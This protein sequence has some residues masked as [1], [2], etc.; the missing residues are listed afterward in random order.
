MRQ[1]MLPLIEDMQRPVAR[2][3]SFHGYNALLDTG[4]VFPIW[5]EDE[6]ILVDLGGELVKEHIEF[7]GFGGR[8]IGKLFRLPQI[9]VGELIYPN[10]HIIAYKMNMPCYFIM[11]AT[12]FQHLIYEIDD[13]NHTLNITIPDKEHNVRNL[14]IKDVNGRLHVFCQ[15]AEE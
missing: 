3:D 5:V 12:M 4:S 9:Q 6:D 7:S 11:S 14:A 2:L 10:F 15:S 1:F 8:S 13:F